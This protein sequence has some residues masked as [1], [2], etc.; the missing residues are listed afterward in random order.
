MANVSLDPRLD[1]F[2]D[3]STATATLAAIGCT[4]IA[5]KFGSLLLHPRRLWISTASFF[6]RLKIFLWLTVDKEMASRSIR[7]SGIYTHPGKWLNRIIYICNLIHIVSVFSHYKFGL[8]IV[9]WHIFSQIFERNF[10]SE[11]SI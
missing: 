6:A 7:I 3:R 9:T 8:I 5:A 10:S 2:V 1:P 11:I 4:V